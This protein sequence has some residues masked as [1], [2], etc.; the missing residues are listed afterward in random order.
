MEIENIENN[1]DRVSDTNFISIIELIVDAVRT[2]PLYELNDTEVYFS[3]V[4]KLLKTDDISL[5]SLK[6]YL[7]NNTNLDE[8][9]EIVW[10]SDSLN[11]LI[12]AFELMQLYRISFNEIKNTIEILR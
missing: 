9:E 8:E 12:E 6:G 5:E 7:G 1:I 3:E 10:I 11:S 2:Y 4:K